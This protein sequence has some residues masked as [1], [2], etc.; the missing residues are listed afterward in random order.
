MILAGAIQVLFYLAI[1][2]LISW[3]VT[4]ISLIAG[5]FIIGLLRPLVKMA[6]S[7]GI[8]QTRIFQSLLIRLT[9]LLNGI[10]PVKAMGREDQIQAL[11]SMCE[12]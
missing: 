3:Q 8:K 1:A 10:K 6:R 11:K 7:A 4:V 9:E 12:I 2:L 5:L